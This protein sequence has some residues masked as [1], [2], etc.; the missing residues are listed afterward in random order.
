[1]RRH[2]G[3][4][5]KK[6]RAGKKAK[7]TLPWESRDPPPDTATHISPVPPSGDDVCGTEV[8]G[9]CEQPVWVLGTELRSSAK[10]ECT[11]NCRA[12]SPALIAIF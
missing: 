9:G 4:S 11:F 2:R 10:A 1:M 3:L 5:W 7:A 12:I 8:M 6:G